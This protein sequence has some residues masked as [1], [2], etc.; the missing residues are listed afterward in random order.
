MITASYNPSG[1]TE[2]LLVEGHSGE[3]TPGGSVVCAAVSTLLEFT[4]FMLDRLN[5]HGKKLCTFE[6]NDGY[7]S[8]IIDKPESI[9]ENDKEVEAWLR[10]SF[11]VSSAAM[12]LNGLSLDHPKLIRYKK[13]SSTKGD[14]DVSTHKETKAPK[15]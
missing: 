10:A 5:K 4:Q 11:I 7:H 9:A 15:A 1:L 12:S 13:P 14:D 2:I 8:I 6:K 3:Q